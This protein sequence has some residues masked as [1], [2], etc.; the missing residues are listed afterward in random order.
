MLTNWLIPRPAAEGGDYI[1]QQ[2]CTQPNWYLAVSSFLNANLPN[3]W[4]GHVGQHC[5]VF[6]NRLSNL[7]VC[8]FFLGDCVKKKRTSITASLNNLQKP[9]TKTLHAITPD[10]LKSLARAWLSRWYWLSK[11]GAH[12]DCLWSTNTTWNLVYAIIPANI[13]R[14]FKFL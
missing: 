10:M 14:L 1:F 4:I 13:I 5:H 7:P 2:D 8:D 9:I 12:I 11:K 3:R 6:C